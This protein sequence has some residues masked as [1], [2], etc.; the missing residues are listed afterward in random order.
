MLFRSGSGVTASSLTSVGASLTIGGNTALH[1]G[2]Y[3]SYAPTLQGGNAS[4]TWGIRVTGFA[5]AGSPKLYSTD[6]AYNYD[7]ANPYYGY[8]TYD[9]SRWL[10]QVSPATPAAVRVAYAD[11][12]GSATS[13]TSATSASYASTLSS[14]DNRTLAPIAFTAARAQ[15]G[16]TSWTNN[17]TGPWAD[18][19]VLRSYTDS[20][21]GNDNLVM[22]RKD[23][24][25]MRI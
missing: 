15:F 14:W 13:A 11:T 20:S 12:A 6:A 21:G 17:N 9:G 3:N 22:F 1:A 24:I 25:G 4:G 16:F 10:F 8:L 19:F 5:N 7:S 18:Y 23:A 2:N